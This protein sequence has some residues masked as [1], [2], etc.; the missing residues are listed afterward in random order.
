M[1][2]CTILRAK[3]LFAARFEALNRAVPGV[4]I[5]GC[6]AADGVMAAGQDKRDGATWASSCCLHIIFGGATGRAVA[7]KWCHHGV[8]G[9]LSC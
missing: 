9:D 2:R 7:P 8:T 6:E 1:R 5:V 4:M 3:L